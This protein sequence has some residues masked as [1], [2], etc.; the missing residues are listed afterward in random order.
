MLFVIEKT[1]SSSIRQCLWARSCVRPCAG[2]L[3]TNW[4]EHL[5]VEFREDP[6]LI[7][8]VT[9]DAGEVVM[10]VDLQHE[11]DFFLRNSNGHNT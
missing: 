5:D 1:R 7:A 11:L 9:V 10:H 6:R 8:G 2:L 4:A 3:I